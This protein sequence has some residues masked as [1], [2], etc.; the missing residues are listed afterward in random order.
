MGSIDDLIAV[1]DLDTRTDQLRHRRD[2]LPALV[3]LA[4]AEAA[5]SEVAGRA[6]VV[7]ARLHDLRRKEKA[8][9]DE[10]SLVEDHA[11]EIER[12]L[13]D[14]SVVAHK[15]LEAFQA[16]HRSLKAR[17]SEIEDQALELL[18]EAEPVAAEVEGLEAELAAHDAR[19]AELTADLQDARIHLDGEIAELLSQRGALAEGVPSEVLEAYESIRT[20]LGGVGAA[21]LTGNRCEGCHLE[22]PSAELEA[23]RH[24]PADAVLACP[25]CSRILVR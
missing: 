12:K 8:L 5:R 13:Y 10:A 7:G 9:E 11:A 17:Q 2:T 1:Q 18:E 4:D 15:E 25:E 23:L 21:R 22:I 24:A 16:D 6:D 20:R 14:G 19:I 3:A